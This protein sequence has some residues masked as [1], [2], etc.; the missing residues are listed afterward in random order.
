MSPHNSAPKERPPPPKKASPAQRKRPAEPV[1]PLPSMDSPP[2]PSP[3]RPKHDS[4]HKRHKSHR[5]SSEG[6]L[7]ADTL[8]EI[9]QFKELG[10]SWCDLYPDIASPEARALYRQTYDRDFSSYQ[11][12][13]ETVETGIQKMTDYLA[14]LNVLSRESPEHKH[15]KKKATRLY[16]ENKDLREKFSFLHDKL[17]VVK[18]QIEQFDKSH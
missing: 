12:L 2:P 17:S 1:S 3:K 6:I 11:R 15:L 18:R 7:S 8:A 10:C 16:E 9:S 5:S 13:R 14:Q 4:P